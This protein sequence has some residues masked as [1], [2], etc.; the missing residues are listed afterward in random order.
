MSLLGLPAEL[1]VHI[2]G[3][4]PPSAHFDFALTS[5]FCAACSRDVL[6]YHRKCAQQYSVISNL[7]PLTVPSV[8]RTV[9]SD[10][11]IAWHVRSVESWGTRSSWIEWKE[12]V[13]PGAEGDHLD[14]RVAQQDGTS[15]DSGFWSSMEYDYFERFLLLDMCNSATEARFWGRRQPERGDDAALRSLLVAHCPRMDGLTFTDCDE[16]LT[17]VRRIR[18]A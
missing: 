11:I 13:T 4:L 3:Y 8:L 2:I 16:E 17:W 5:R 18:E 12:F 15:L 7:S 6:R 9:I 1:L 10:P 14:T